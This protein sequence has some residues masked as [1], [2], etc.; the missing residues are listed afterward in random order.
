MPFTRLFAAAPCCFKDGRVIRFLLSLRKSYTILLKMAPNSHI[1]TRE[2][3]ERN[4][5]CSEDGNNAVFPLPARHRRNRRLITTDTST[6]SS[7]SRAISLTQL[8]DTWTSTSLT[9]LYTAGRAERNCRLCFLKILLDLFFVMSAARY[10]PDIF[11][12][13]FCV[14]NWFHWTLC[15][16]SSLLWSWMNKN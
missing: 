11:I 14:T 10:L 3:C 16:F 15:C 8:K 9:K 1:T 13:C 7:D 12:L 4:R 2:L 6:L 5:Y